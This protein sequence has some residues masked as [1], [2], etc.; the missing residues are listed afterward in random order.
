MNIQMHKIY[1]FNHFLP[2]YL[3]TNLFSVVSSSVFVC[4]LS[5]FAILDCVTFCSGGV[6]QLGS[7]LI[8]ISSSENKII[9][10][11]KIC[12]FSLYIQYVPTS[13]FECN[14]LVLWN[15]AQMCFFAYVS[16]TKD[17]QKTA[18]LRKMFWYWGIL[19]KSSFFLMVPVLGH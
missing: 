4:L 3:L 12:C 5:S 6:L 7:T 16:S 9:L 18:N 17:I 14:F 13:R 19:F 2:T 15:F 8:R 10:F 11:L 1:T